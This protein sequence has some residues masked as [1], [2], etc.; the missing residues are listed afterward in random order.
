MSNPISTTT[1]QGPTIQQLLA[2]MEEMRAQLAALQPKAAEAEVF[3]ST[4]FYHLVEGSTV[5]IDHP[6]PDGSHI[7]EVLCFFGGKLTTSDPDT[8]RQLR[9]IANKP[10]VP[11]TT[12]KTSGVNI[13]AEEAQALVKAAAMK[14]IDKLGAEATIKA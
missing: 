3:E 2:Q 9:A 8:I 7:A 12:K 14:S 1:A 10:G 13:D 6:Q 5:V 11:I 4:T